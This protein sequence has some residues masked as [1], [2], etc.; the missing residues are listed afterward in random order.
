MHKLRGQSLQFIVIFHNQNIR[1]IEQGAW[2]GKKVA[3]LFQWGYKALHNIVSMQ[4]LCR[5]Y[6][7]M[8]WSAIVLLTESAT[9]FSCTWFHKFRDFTVQWWVCSEWPLKI[10]IRKFCMRYILN[11]QFWLN[12]SRVISKSVRRGL[13]L[14]V[15]YRTSLN[16]I[17]FLP[18]RWII[19]YWRTRKPV[20]GILLLRSRWRSSVD[21][22]RALDMP[23][24]LWRGLTSRWRWGWKRGHTDCDQPKWREFRVRLF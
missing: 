10:C 8:H 16:R 11:I 6:N 21:A 13:T 1:F 7:V 24:Q 15:E 12:I 4:F 20:H 14:L 3:L 17:M 18:W 2:R 22:G 9:F 19:L 23:H 5:H